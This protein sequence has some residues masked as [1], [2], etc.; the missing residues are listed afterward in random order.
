MK[1]TTTPKAA[2]L[3]VA[4]QIQKIETSV[5]F[6]C[7]PSGDQLLEVQ[8][9]CQ[10]T[11]ALGQAIELAEGAR[12]FTERLANDANEFNVFSVDE[13]RAISFLAESSAAITRAVVRSMSEGGAQ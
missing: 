9:G 3:R 8:V 4:T 13:L 2:Q 7:M 11:E 10:C 6:A 12:L 5:M 1:S